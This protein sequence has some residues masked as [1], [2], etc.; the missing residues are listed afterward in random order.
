MRLVYAACAFIS[1]IALVVIAAARFLDAAPPDHLQSVARYSSA[2][3][4]TMAETDPGFR[5]RFIAR[6]NP[7]VK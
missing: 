3:V 2:I 1:T 4:D 7:G 6:L 5:D